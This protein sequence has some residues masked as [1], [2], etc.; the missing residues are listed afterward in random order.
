MFPLIPTSC[1]GYQ[2][3]STGGEHEM[4]GTVS[5]RLDG[6]PVYGIGGL[7]GLG[8]RIGG[9]EPASRDWAVSADGRSPTLPR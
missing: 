6:R 3:L 5:G 4:S 7:D 9:Q 1:N 2:Q 8:G